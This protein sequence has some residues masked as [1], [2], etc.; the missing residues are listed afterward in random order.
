MYV[1][2]ETGPDML[3][4]INYGVVWMWPNPEVVYFPIIAHPDILPI[5]EQHGVLFQLFTVPFSVLE[6]LWN[7]HHLH[8]NG[9]KQKFPRQSLL[10]YS[11]LKN[12]VSHVTKKLKC[13]LSWR[14]SWVTEKIK[15]TA[16][17][18]IVK[19]HWRWRLL[20]V[21]R[22]CHTT[23]GGITIETIMYYNEQINTNLAAYVSA[24]TTVLEN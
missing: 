5:K 11:L 4:I 6:C 15:S 14:L 2:H 23:P 16:L 12:A 9:Y 8:Y 1:Q 10:V 7:G 20:P 3:I 18:L 22:V 19:R 24:R 17:P 21:W 13:L